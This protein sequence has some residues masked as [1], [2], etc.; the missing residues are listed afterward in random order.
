MD[1]IPHDIT[2]ADPGAG[3]VRGVKYTGKNTLALIE[4]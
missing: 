4:E 3:R 1:V 2:L